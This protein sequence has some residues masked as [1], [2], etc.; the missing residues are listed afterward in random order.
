MNPLGSEGDVVPNFES[1]NS[2][3][4]RRNDVVDFTDPINVISLHSEKQFCILKH[5]PF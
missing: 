4:S 5:E 2:E 1:F 3:I